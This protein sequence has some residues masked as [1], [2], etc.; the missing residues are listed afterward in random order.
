MLRNLAVILGFALITI[1]CDEVR[2]PTIDEAG[3]SAKTPQLG[4]PMAP[5]DSF[6]D[7]PPVEPPVNQ[8]SSGKEPPVR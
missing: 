3:T 7:L 2:K 4:R 5:T 1:A 8:P 6:T